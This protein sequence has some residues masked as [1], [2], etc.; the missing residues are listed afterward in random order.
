MIKHKGFTI[1]ELLVV[2]VVIA[3]LASITIISY[4]WLRG[5]AVDSKIR[6]VVKMAGDA[7]SLYEGQGNARLAHGEFSVTD[8][9]DALVS[10]KLLKV[11]YR[12]GLQ[13]KNVQNPNK[14]F[15]FRSCPDTDRTGSMVIYA[16]LNNPTSEDINNFN[17]V[18]NQCGHMA[19]IPAAGTNAYNYAQIF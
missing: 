12:D 11:G 5:D 13:S 2:I 15:L 3:V 14:I 18:R 1:V 17:N 19:S 4:S 10:K 7:E 8:G 9:I 6:A 16:S